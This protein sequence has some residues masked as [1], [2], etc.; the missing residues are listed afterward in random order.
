MFWAQLNLV[1][2]KNIYVGIAPEFPPL[3]T[4]LLSGCQ[5]I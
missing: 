5:H 1:G 3:A 4:D 2:H